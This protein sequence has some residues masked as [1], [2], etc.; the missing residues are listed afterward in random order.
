M[1]SIRHLRN[2][3]IY[4]SSVSKRVPVIPVLLQ[5]HNFTAVITAYLVVFADNLIKLYTL[6][7]IRYVF[8]SVRNW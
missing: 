8:S 7:V 3:A 2:G 6:A 4:G 1:L 5:P